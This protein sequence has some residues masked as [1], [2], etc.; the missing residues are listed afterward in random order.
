MENK[1]FNKT[2]CMIVA[3]LVLM[4]TGCKENNDSAQQP[5]IESFAPAMGYEGDEVTI[6]GDYFSSVKADNIVRFGSQQ[7][8]VLNASFNQLQ[9]RV[10]EDAIDGKITVRVEGLTASSSEEFVVLVDLEK[11]VEEAM[12][13]TNIPSLAMAVVTSSGLKYS[14]AFG[15]YDENLLKEADENT[16]Y[17]TSSIGK[18]VVSVA[19]MQQVEL[20]RLSLD[21]HISDLVGFEVRNPN[22]PDTEITVQMVMEHGSSLSNPFAGEITQDVLLAYEPDSA[23]ALHPTIEDAITPVSS[24]YQ[25]GIWMNVEPGSFHKNSN[26][27]ITLLGYM[28]EKLS[29]KHFNDYSRDHILSPLGM[30]SSSYYY[31]DLDEDKVAVIY[32]PDGNPIAPFSYFFY[33]AGMLR[34]STSD[35]V[36]FLSMMLNKGTYNGNQ[37][38]L[39]GSVRALLD[40]KYPASNNIAYDSS[41]GLV[42]RQAAGSEGWIGHTGA[43]V[44]ITHITELNRDKDLAFVIF[45]NRV[46]NA[47]VIGPGGTLYNQVHRWLDQI[48]SQD[49]NSN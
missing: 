28:V 3:A 40:M 39:P 2:Y 7:A 21:Q 27:G 10:P 4:Q 1:I 32:G 25:E 11:E 16:L 8:E 43:G 6:V 46:G 26:Y 48:D 41:I 20:G 30:T 45:S 23:I 35:W 5:E 15:H 42:W 22:F 33:P 24:I 37:I 14:N 12:I 9:V 18:L 38:L 29:G 36:K 17:I 47:A 49:S 31:P 13:S 19:V 34:T 44:G